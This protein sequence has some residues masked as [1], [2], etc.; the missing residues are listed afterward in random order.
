M[1]RQPADWEASTIS[2]IPRLRHR[3]AMS[4]MGR[5]KP[6]TLETWVHTAARTSGVSARRKASRAAARSNRGLSATRTVTPGMARSG[7]V[8][9]LCS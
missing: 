9:A 4:S 8:T 6:N 2:G 1:G 3:A 5:M 7:R